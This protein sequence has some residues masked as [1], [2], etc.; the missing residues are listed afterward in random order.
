MVTGLCNKA[1][2]RGSV[3]GVED[4][5]D[6][7][8]DSCSLMLVSRSAREDAPESRMQAMAQN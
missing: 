3:G 8:R 7:A 2:I 5:A 4:D 6:D 1:E